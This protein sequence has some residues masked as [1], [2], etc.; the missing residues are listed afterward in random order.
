M[1]AAIAVTATTSATMPDASASVL[2][3]NLL[4]GGREGFCLIGGCA[5]AGR[6][7]RGGEPAGLAGARESRRA[8]AKSPQRPY[9]SAGDFARARTMTASTAFGNSGLRA[10]GSGT[11]SWTWANNVAMVSSRWNGRVPVSRTNATQASAYWSV[12]PSTRAALIRSGAQ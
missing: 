8:A 10:V 6:G 4:P 1:F 11:G 2:V 9:L 5:G 3:L 7:G 12:R